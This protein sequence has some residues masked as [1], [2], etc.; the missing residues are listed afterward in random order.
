MICT[1]IRSIVEELRDRVDFEI[2]AVDNFCPSEMEEKS[3]PDRGHQ[4]VYS[5][6]DGMPWLR[7]LTYNEKLSHW[8]AKRV[9][10]ESSTASFLFFSDAHCMVSRDALFN[11]F[12]FYR[13][14]YKDL[15]GTIHLPLTY[16]ILEERKLIYNL[17]WEPEVGDVHYTFCRA[18]DTPVYEVPCMSSCGMMMT[19]ELYNYVGGWP[20]ELGIYGGGENF[21]NFTLAVLGKKKWV[22]ETKPL[23][24]HGEERGYRWH[25]TDYERNRIIASYLFGGRDWTTRFIDRRKKNY[26][27]QRKRWELYRNV[28]DKCEEHREWI[29]ERQVMT[30]EEWGPL[31]A[32]EKEIQNVEGVSP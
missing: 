32:G 11:M 1:T 14:Y 26:P 2:I 15:D 20:T 17:R 16:H 3:E 18:K 7:V 13:S 23:Y 5:M 28:L 30:I 9:A 19:R 4:M 10:V 29:K 8:Q 24:H 21:M 22:F 27:H 6:A 12:R 31:W 25:A